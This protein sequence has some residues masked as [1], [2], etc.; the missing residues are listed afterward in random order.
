MEGLMPPSLASQSIEQLDGSSSILARQRRD[1]IRLDTLLGK[2]AAAE[3]PTDS[4]PYRAIRDCP[5]FS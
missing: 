4:N 5:G 2:C 1:H 3:G